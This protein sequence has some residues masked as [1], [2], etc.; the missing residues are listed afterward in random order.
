MPRSSQPEGELIPLHYGGEGDEPA[1]PIPDYE[2]EMS[3]PNSRDR[4]WNVLATPGTYL[5]LGINCAVFLW[6]VLH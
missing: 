5:L 6:M 4:G 2:R 1:H 3:R